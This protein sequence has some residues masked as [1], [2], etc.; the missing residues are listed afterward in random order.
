MR[1]SQ[2]IAFYWAARVGSFT[3]AADELGMTQPSVSELVKRLEIEIGLDLFVRAGRRL[4]LT[5]AGRTLLPWAERLRDDME[6]AQQAMD[7]LLGVTGG[8]ASFGLLRNASFYFLSELAMR[9]HRERP[10]VQIRLIGQNSVEV[11]AAVRSGELEAG[12]VVLPVKTDGLDV[13]PIVRDEVLWGSSELSRVSE[14]FKVADI[15]QRPLILYDAHY[16][17]DDPTRSQ[18]RDLAQRHGFNLAP[19]IE[20]ENVDSALALV[21]QGIGETIVSGAV[22]RHE[23]FPPEIHTVGFEQPFFDTIALIQREGAALSPVTKELAMMA[24]RMLSES[25]LEPA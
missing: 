3:A 11:A 4:V 16:G 15:A 20:V 7:E 6:N 22:A 19:S 10:G 14:P 13:Y 23:S 21:A 24:T 1:N 8:T 5:E 17:W 9:F 2:I 25:G 12:L 18:L